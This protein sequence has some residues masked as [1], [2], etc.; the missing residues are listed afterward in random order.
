MGRAIDEAMRL[1]ALSM[2]NERQLAARGLDRS[3]LPAVVYGWQTEAPVAD[4]PFLLTREIET[5]PT[6]PDSIAA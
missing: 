2:L 1:R 4:V 3:S 5:G 6:A